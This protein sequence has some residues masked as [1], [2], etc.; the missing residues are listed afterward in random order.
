MLSM[1]YDVNRF[2]K[3]TPVDVLARVVFEALNS[4]EVQLNAKSELHVNNTDKYPAGSKPNKDFLA[5]INKN[6]MRLSVPTGKGEKRDLL[7]SDLDGQP[8]RG[9]NFVGMTSS[10][11]PPSL[12]EFPNDK[13]WGFHSN[14]VGPFY[15][16]VLNIAGVLEIIPFN[17]FL[18]TQYLGKITGAGAP[19][20]GNFPLQNDWGFKNRTGTGQLYLAFNQ[21]GAAVKFVELT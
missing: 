17:P 1:A 7:I 21:T 5:T 15:Y 11:L 20:V 4:I 3:N 6:K 14:T 2:D 8:N 12:T 10:A 13:D 9:L 19:S 16:F 18:N